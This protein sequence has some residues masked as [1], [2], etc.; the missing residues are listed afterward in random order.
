MG[1]APLEGVEVPPTQGPQEGVRLATWP[2][3]PECRDMDCGKCYGAAWDL[4]R[5]EEV[6][7]QHDCHS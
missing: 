7:C 5:D 2:R 3:S 6:A 1:E 4:E